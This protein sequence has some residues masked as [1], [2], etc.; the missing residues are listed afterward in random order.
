[1]NS[2]T[3]IVSSEAPV[4]VNA[5]IDADANKKCFESGVTNDQLEVKENLKNGDLILDNKD[6]ELLNKNQSDGNFESVEES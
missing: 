5:V 1:M 6:G 3:I 2:E 4:T